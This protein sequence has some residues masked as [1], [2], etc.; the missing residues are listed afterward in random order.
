MAA[1]NN[2]QWFFPLFVKVFGVKKCK[3]APAMWCK[4]AADVSCFD[5]ETQIGS[6]CLEI[7]YKDI[8]LDPTAD[9]RFEK[10]RAGACHQFRYQ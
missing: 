3:K 7:A 4:D 6:H 5:G 9:D 10:G 2:I 8:L 1:R